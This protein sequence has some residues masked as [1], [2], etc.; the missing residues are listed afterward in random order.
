VKID[1]LKL[2]ETAGRLFMTLLGRSWRI[3]YVSPP[4]TGRL[5]RTR[6]RNA[7]FA[8]WHGR[9]LPLIFTHRFENV[10]VL[11]S[12][13]RDGL[14][15]ANVLRS[16]GFPTVRGSA[17]KGGLAAMRNMARLLRKGI[18]CAITPDGPRGPECVVQKGIA[19]IAHS[20]RVPIV[21]IGTS[22]WPVLR[23]NSWDHFMFPLPFARMTVVEGRPV[24]PGGELSPAALTAIVQ[25]EMNRVSSLADLTASPA[26]RMQASL[27]RTLGRFASIPAGVGLLTRSKSERMERRG[28]CEPSRDHPVWLHGSSIGELQGLLPLAEDLLEMDVAVHVTCF[29]P[30]G[31]EILERTGIRCSL[32]PLDNPRWV[33]RFLDRLAPSALILAETELWPNI[34][35]TSVMRGIPAMMVNA[36][37]SERSLSR[38]SKASSLVAGILSCFTAILCRSAEDLTRYAKLGVPS[39]IL[40]LAGDSKSLA[41]SEPAPESW[42]IMLHASGRKVLLAGSTRPGEEEQV[43]DAAV[44]AGWLPVIAPRHLERVGRVMELAADRGLSP[45]PWSSLGNGEDEGKDFGSVVL[46]V[47]GI[48]ASLYGAADAA[49]VG[50]TFAPIGGHNVLEPLQ[51][52]VP[53]IVGKNHASFAGEI[54]YASSEG[55]GFVVEDSDELADT[56]SQLADNPVDEEIARR[57]GRLAGEQ[58]HKM[59]TY[60]LASMGICRNSKGLTGEKT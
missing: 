14:Y 27:F 56:L 46:D 37:L 26:A 30:S 40:R 7:L 6:G 17:S 16:M 25:A 45:V 5:G 20:G 44:K 49:F 22:A 53:V 59:F 24:Q 8:L 57:A 32:I 55:V 13:S 18:D 1:L 4:A 12:M 10:H 35:H 50:G 43:L 15:A 33:E 41:R 21:P 23:L 54:R 3:F 47:H 58:F 60:V 36:R 39:R 9:Q 29:T 2:S 31:R 28:F 38:Y 51:Q 34:L 11:V 48:L 19:H 42:R 52:G